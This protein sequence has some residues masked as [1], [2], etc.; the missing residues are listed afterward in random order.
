MLF[1]AGFATVRAG[2]ATNFLA[3]VDMSLL[4]FF[5]SRGISYK[6]NGL[7]G[8]ALILLKERGINAVRLRL[9]TSSASQAA[10]NPY[11]YI[12]NTDYTLPLAIRVKQVGLQSV[13]DFHYSDTWADPAHQITPSAWTNLSYVDL[14]TQMRSYT[15]NTLAAFKS[16]GALPDYVQVGNEITGGLLWPNGQLYGGADIAGQ[17]NKVGQLIGAAVQGVK[18]VA[19][20]GRP[21]IIVHIDRGGDWAGTKYFFDNLLNTQHVSCDV[22]GLSYYPFYHGPLGNLAN[23]LTNVALTYGK[24]VML[25][26]TAFPWT[27]SI[28][29]TNIYGYSPT[30]NGQ[31]QFVIALAQLVK[32]VPNGLG[33]GIFWWGTEYQ[34]KSGV[35]TAGFETA[36]FFSADG[37]MLPVASAFGQLTAPLALVATRSVTH[38]TL[39]WPLSGAGMG[40]VTASTL[41]PDSVW[42]PLAL[43]VQST[44]TV[45]YAQLPAGTNQGQYFRLQGN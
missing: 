37:N 25:C 27:N 16:A 42:S 20:N 44:G 28:W 38:L 5:E 18:D 22:I 1:L 24:P 4:P 32:Q 11:N 8:D 33:A 35:N 29:A 43:D 2:A 19:T 30:T 34:K 7:T 39:S 26:E 12:N 36:S 6:D 15:S 17:W 40:L 3:G 9:F 45:I 14:V 41:G 10:A 31:T 21:K 23:C 13:L